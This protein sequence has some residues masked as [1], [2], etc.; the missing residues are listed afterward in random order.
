MDCHTAIVQQHPSSIPV[1]LP[2]EGSL[3]GLFL[4]GLFHRVAQGVDLGVGPAGGDDKIVRQGGQVRNLNGAD[5]LALLLVQG[6][7]RNNGQFF[8][9]HRHASLSRKYVKGGFLV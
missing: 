3:S 9:C 7:G 4:H 1:P 2:V 5:F 6:L 8:R